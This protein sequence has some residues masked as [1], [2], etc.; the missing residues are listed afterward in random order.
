MGIK[1]N[2]IAVFCGSSAGLNAHYTQAAEA[3]GQLLAQQRITLVYGGAQIGL[4][5]SV[6]NAALAQG[7]KVV[8]VI[9]KL[10]MRQE[11]VHQGLSELHVVDTLAQRKDLMMARA[12]AFIVLPG[13]IGTLDE[14]FEVW[15]TRQL[16]LHDKPLGLL[17]TA[18]YF[19]SLQAFIQQAV[20]QGFLRAQHQS[21]L[22]VQAEPMQLLSALQMA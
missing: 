15:T 4:M 7:G 18:G 10:L 20:S 14:L 3:L 22:R 9:P 6:A 1:L 2:A 5:G 16:G 19:N 12:E 11:L 17:N 13:G 21:L 8:G